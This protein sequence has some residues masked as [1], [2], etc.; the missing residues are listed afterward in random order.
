[1]AQTDSTEAAEAPKASQRLAAASETAIA[2]AAGVAQF[3]EGGH[4]I[5]AEGGS[6]ASRLG[7]WSWALYEAARDPNIVFQIYVI[8]PF[9][10]TVMMRDPIRG[11]EL[12]G[13]IAAYSGY[14]TAVLAP[15][16]GA[17]ADRGGPRKPWLALFTLLMVISFAG[18]WV[19]VPNSTAMQ[20]F[21]VAAMVVVNNIVFEFSNAFHGAMLPSIAPASRLGG[22]SGLAFALGSGAGFLLMIVFLVCFIAPGLAHWS[23][24]PAHPLFG[25]DPAKHEAERLSGPISALWMLALAIPLFLFT[26]DRASTGVPLARAVR[27]GIGAVIATVRSLG[28]YKN[29]AHYIGA[30][31]L[32]NDG[33]T[34]VL[35]FSGIYAA[36]SFHLGALAMTVYGVQLMLFAML[37][38]FLGGW[39]DDKLGSKTALL[40]SIGGTM[41][42]FALVLTMGPDRIFWFIPIDP[43]A[44]PVLPIP[45]FNTWP[46]I[47]LT[48]FSSLN[49]LFIVAGYANTRTMMARIA[50][51]EKMTEFFGL[52]SLS[53]TA[54]TFLAP[55][56][57][58]WLTW[59]THS[60]RGGMVAIVALLAA[61]WLWLFWVREERA[62]AL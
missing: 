37:G 48:I 26:P 38:G 9:F 7:Q 46:Q 42:S 8:S 20:I 57:V 22:L 4:R 44:P 23:F 16:F 24:L 31:S 21:I 39:L 62:Q 27:E 54:T 45:F 35:T 41:I 55:V 34:G 6:A 56:S 36:G 32:F 15:F 40:I 61:G 1:M 10:A 5:S 59:W 30:R 2:D 43:H 14:I 33:M 17:I 25:L 3:I 29:V 11:Q 51:F 13:N 19:G 28:H 12:W 60:Q 18:T 47:V 49:A 50:P 52:M 58:A 53:G